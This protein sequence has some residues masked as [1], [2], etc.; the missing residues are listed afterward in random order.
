M[1]RSEAFTLTNEVFMGKVVFTKKVGEAELKYE[2]EDFM[3]FME[4]ES[5]AEY[6]AQVEVMGGVEK[7]PKQEN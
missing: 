1:K 2:F 7:P 6:D 4:F 3:D 5:V